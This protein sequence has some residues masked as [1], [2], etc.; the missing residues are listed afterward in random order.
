MA[1]G[2]EQPAR[3]LAPWPFP[4][5]RVK[6]L[7]NILAAVR[8]VNAGRDV[9]RWRRLDPCVDLD[10]LQPGQDGLQIL[11]GWSL[12]HR[13]SLAGRQ[14]T[15]QVVLQF[16][17]PLHELAGTQQRMVRDVPGWYRPGMNSWLA[18]LAAA[19]LF[20]VPV[21][22]EVRT[23]DGDTLKLDDGKLYRLWGIDAAEQGQRCADGWRAGIEARTTLRELI[24]G[25]AIACEPLTNDRYGRIVALCRA[26][27]QDLGAAM[28]SAGM[29]WAFVKY[30]GDYVEHE[31]TATAEHIGVHAHDCAKPW[32]WRALTRSRPPVSEA[33]PR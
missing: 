19:A 32:D 9:R 7:P 10:L 29:A 33:G 20:T 16:H 15:G 21:A 4:A 28:V 25:H 6:D 17:R 24:A 5:D 13:T 18:P 2:V 11:A 26:D 3:N 1:G 27:G 8:I 30:S 14:D 12:G 23:V 22:A 31:R